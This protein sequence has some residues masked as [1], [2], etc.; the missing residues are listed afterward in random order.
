MA[1]IPK[2]REMRLPPRRLG[3]CTHHL[4]GDGAAP[5]I[6]RTR[7]S[8]W[9]PQRQ[10][11]CSCHPKGKGDSLLVVEASRARSPYP[12]NSNGSNENELRISSNRMRATKSSRRG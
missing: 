5:T 4:E 6:T 1:A 9:P 11:R 10:G 7:Q 2:K 3:K 12:G 8:L